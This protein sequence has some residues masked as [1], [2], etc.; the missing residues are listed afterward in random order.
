MKTLF[1]LSGCLTYTAVIIA[2]IILIVRIVR[3]FLES[4]AKRVKALLFFEL[5][6]VAVI[7]TMLGVLFQNYARTLA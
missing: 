5:C 1:T 2:S 6:S 3:A 4:D 7:G